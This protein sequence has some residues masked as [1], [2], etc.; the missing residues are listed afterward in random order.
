[1]ENT[2][3]PLPVVISSAFSARANG[4]TAILTWTT[5]SETNNSHFILEKGTNGTNFSTLSTIASKGNGAQYS[6]TDFSPAD[7]TNYYRL[8]QIDNNGTIVSYQPVAINFALG[9]QHVSI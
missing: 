2:T 3:T 8:T 5:A 7:G 1:Y 9:A 6:Y 4:N